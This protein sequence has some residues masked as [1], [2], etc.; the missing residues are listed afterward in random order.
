MIFTPHIKQVS[1]LGDLVEFLL[2]CLGLGADYDI[3][4]FSC[5]SNVDITCA[6]SHGLT[7]E[8]IASGDG[9]WSFIFPE[10]HPEEFGVA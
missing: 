6:A 10:D 2:S 1:L 3:F 8:F 9:I 5:V 4:L 7:I